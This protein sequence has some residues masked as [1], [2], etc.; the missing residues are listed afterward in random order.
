MAT[1]ATTGDWLVLFY[2]PDD[3]FN[4]KALLKEA[5]KGSGSCKVSYDNI[6]VIAHNQVK[7]EERIHALGKELKNEKACPIMNMKSYD[8]IVAI[9]EESDQTD[10]PVTG[11]LKRFGLIHER[12]KAP[13][14]P[15]VD[16]ISLL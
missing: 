13:T 14:L 12:T 6:A 10:E 9:V 5:Y 1:G 7:V 2:S 15:T 3:T 11:L 8:Q 16:C 4:C